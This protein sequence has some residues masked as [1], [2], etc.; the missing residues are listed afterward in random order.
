MD[1]NARSSKYLVRR[2]DWEIDDNDVNRLSRSVDSGSLSYSTRGTEKIKY[3]IA[4]Q[5]KNTYEP[6]D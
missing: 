1:R 5:K 3:S 2:D 4:M 6:V